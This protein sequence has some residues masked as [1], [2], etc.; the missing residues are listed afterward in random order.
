MT[1]AKKTP[2]AKAA[3]VKKIAKKASAPKPVPAASPV[4]RMLADVPEMLAPPAAK[5]GFW[6]RLFS[7]SVD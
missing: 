5:K 6:A 4:T 3:P 7:W 1:A 2:R